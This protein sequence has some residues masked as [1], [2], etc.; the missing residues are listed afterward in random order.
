VIFKLRGATRSLVFPV[1]PE[2]IRQNGIARVAGFDTL[3]E[4]IEQ[5]RGSSPKRWGWDGILP[6]PARRNAPWIH[7]Q[8]WEDPE[9]LAAILDQWREENRRLAFTVTETRIAGERVFVSS[10]EFTRAGGFDDISYSIEL[11]EYRRLEVER[12][13]KRKRK[14]EPK[15]P[16]DKA[17]ASGKAGR[18]T[19]LVRYTVKSGDTLQKIARRFLGSTSRW[20][21]IYDDN[22]KVIGSNPNLIFPGQVLTIRTD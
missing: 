17:K 12:H 4:A 1:N 11:V 13:D 14:R 10:F 2:A 3:N 7:T 22:R 9:R 18:D 6:G 15:R 20:K 8:H 16:A 5:P 21:E 19:K